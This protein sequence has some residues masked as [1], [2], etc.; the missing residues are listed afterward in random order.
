MSLWRIFKPTDL[1]DQDICSV[2]SSILFLQILRR[3]ISILVLAQFY[4]GV[5]LL[6]QS[7]LTPSS[8]HSVRNWFVAS[9]A[10][11]AAAMVPISVLLP[12]KSSLHPWQEACTW[13]YQPGHLNQR[14][15][16][17]LLLFPFPIRAETGRNEIIY[18]KWSR[19]R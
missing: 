12:L 3:S 4:I 17:E 16:I 1:L 6:D 8:P 10:I 5:P 2:V 7:Y 13:Y 19:K 15:F 9:P 14:L 18:I 11:Y